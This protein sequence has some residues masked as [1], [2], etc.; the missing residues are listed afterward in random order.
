M[1]R[2]KP[3]HVVLP[4][5]RIF[6]YIGPERVVH[7]KSDEERATAVRELIDRRNKIDNFYDNLEQ[8]ILA[9]GVKNPIVVNAGWVPVN[10]LEDDYFPQRIR[11]TGKQIL[12]CL[13]LGGSRLWY[14]QKYN[15]NIPCIVNDFV[16]MFD[17]P[18]L[19]SRKE[20]AACFTDDPANVF[21]TRDG[22]ELDPC[23]KP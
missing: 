11:D 13:Q 4:A 15:L 5:N 22:I 1:M 21:I 20:I 18:E 9:N 19:M 17:E 12:V 23:V 16:D 6:N 7:N 2:Y 3:R 10:I 14:A 8:D